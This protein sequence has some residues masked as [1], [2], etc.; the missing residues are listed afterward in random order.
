MNK[1]KPKY[2]SVEETVDHIVK[3]FG[4]DIP[5]GMPL[6]LGKPIGLINALYNRVKSDPKLTLTI[7]TALS[8]EKPLATSDLQARLLEPFVARQWKD[9]PDLDYQT[10][11]RAGKLADNV[12]IHEVYVSAGKIKGLPEMQQNFMNSNYT[13]STRDCNAMGNRVFAHAVA[14]RDTE[15]GV[16]I[17][18]SCNA[19]TSLEA[20]RGFHDFNA[21]GIKAISIGMV[22]SHLPFMFGEAV[23]DETEYDIIIDDPDYYHPLFATPRMP[24]SVPEFMIGLHI[25]TLLK[26]NGTLQIGIGALGDAVAYGLNARHN[27]NE[28]YKKVLNDSGIY[29]TYKDLIDEIGGTDTFEEGLYGSTEM[30]VDGFMQLYKNGVIKRKVYN[31]IGIQKLINDGKFKE[32][33]P[34]D[35]LK[36][37]IEDETIHPYLTQKDFD[38]LKN[39]GVFK[40]SVTYD[41][42][43]LVEGG[44]RYSALL[45]D[46]ANLAA[47]SENCLGD[48]LKNGI[49]L[50]GA[51]FLGPQDF[52]DELNNMSD[53]ELAQFEMVGVD[54]ANQLYGNEVLRSLQRKDG[55]FC[56]AGMKATLLGAICSDMMEDGEVVS[57]VGGQYNFV[58]MAHAL[59]DGRCLMMIK[60]T[61]NEGAK[62]LSNIVYSYGHNTIPR[63]LRDIIVTEYGIAN[64][65]SKPDQEIIKEILNVTDSR[66][67]DELMAEAKKYGKLPEDYEI[68]EQFRNNTPEKLAGILAAPK[69][70]GL[71]PDFPC[72][73]PM[74][75]EEL[76]LTASLKTLAAVAQ[77]PKAAEFPTIMAQLPTEIPDNVKTMVDRMGLLNPKDEAEAG[78]QKQLLLAMKVTGFI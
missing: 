68:P 54:V 73:A 76:F 37:M 1:E 58:S 59:K 25:S 74:T 28:A 35:V 39:I 26:D 61:R 42:G 18:C 44:N 19:D 2:L 64:I 43:E 10:D 47:V 52:Y 48:K 51:F 32:E 72:G 11:L 78:L 41:N 62:V 40:E 34:N 12:K 46:D 13:H 7:Y 55:R 20:I 50:T 77:T 60:S 36:L 70:E 17:S 71:F 14:R 66:F 63:H 15:D 67:Q 33:I 30:L 8:F 21:Q 53:E 27:H 56:N 31:H 49:L 57:G 45:A 69:A 24:I 16:K 22:N 6:G 65:R 3:E 38:A 29:E 5:I 9:V 4:P 23:I 75:V